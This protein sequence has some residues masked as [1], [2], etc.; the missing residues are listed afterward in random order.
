MAR[1]RFLGSIG[2][3]ASN[4]LLFGAI[5]AAWPGLPSRFYPSGG[6]SVDGPRLYFVQLSAWRPY[7]D[8]P[9]IGWPT[10]EAMCPGSAPHT[11]EARLLWSPLP[12]EYDPWRS[13]REPPL[14]A[15]ARLGNH[16]GVQAVT[17]L[18]ATGDPAMDRELVEIIRRRWVFAE[19]QEPGRWQRVRLSGTRPPY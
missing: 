9:D 4:I 2:S 12:E 1:L 13:S 5:I 17:L 3:L 10:D 11:A 18:G 15:C 6:S 7:V 14:F 19:P 16:G 8:N